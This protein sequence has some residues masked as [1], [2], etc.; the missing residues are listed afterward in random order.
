MDLEGKVAM[1]TGASRGIGRVIALLLAAR[2]AHIGV[3]FFRNRDAAERTAGE[4]EALS[5][6]AVLLRGNVGDPDHVERIFAGLEAAFGRCDILISNAA[7]G[8]LRPLLEIEPKHW[9][10]TMNINARALL[11]TT[12]RAAP[13]MAAQGWGR[14]VGLS[15]LGAG[16]VVDDYGV[17]GVSKAAIEALTRYL[18]VELAPKGI[19]VNAV[20]GGTV[21]T[22]ALEHFPHREA[23]IEAARARTP[24]GRLLEPQDLAQAVGFLCSDAAAM[25]CG[26]TLVVD[27]GYSLLG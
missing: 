25:I 13:L 1:V 5:R 6:R 12:Q 22:E 20:S 11:L 14:I 17:V 19:T 18:A 26:Q 27:G 4:I 10:W 7:S 9:E 3:N 8:V 16:R 24:M 23:M 15:S 21:D 2:G